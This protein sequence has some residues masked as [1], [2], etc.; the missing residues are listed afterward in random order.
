MKT[1]MSKEKIESAANFTDVNTNGISK[2]I[3]WNFSKLCNAEELYQFKEAVELI[4]EYAILS[5]L[6]K[7]FIK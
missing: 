6:K 1:W 2:N 3:T 5:E 7:T 4:S